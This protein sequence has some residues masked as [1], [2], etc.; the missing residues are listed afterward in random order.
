LRIG[1]VFLV[2][3][4][5]DGVFIFGDNRRKVGHLEARGRENGLFPAER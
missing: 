3:R 1:M 5:R 4:H 2:D